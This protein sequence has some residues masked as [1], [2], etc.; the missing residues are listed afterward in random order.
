VRRTRGAVAAVVIAAST[1]LG[2]P[3]AGCEALAAVVAA[4]EAEARRAASARVRATD[5]ALRAMV[6]ALS[7]ARC[8]PREAE[9]IFARSPLSLPALTDGDRRVL[10]LCAGP[11][12]LIVGVPPDGALAG[13]AAGAFKSLEGTCPHG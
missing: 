9:A 4:S 3:P 7:G 12:H 5:P 2:A 10:G 11:F 6:E 13:A 1:A 8:P